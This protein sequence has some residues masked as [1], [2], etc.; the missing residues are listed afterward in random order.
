MD[1]QDHIFSPYRVCP[2]GAHVDHQHGLVTGFAIDKGVDLRFDV[3]ED[4]KVVLDSETFTGHVEFDISM[5]CCTMK[6]RHGKVEK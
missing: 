1:Y 2:L 4:S 6:S 5:P 3:L